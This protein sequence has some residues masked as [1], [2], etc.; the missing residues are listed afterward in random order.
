MNI[1]VIPARGGSKR[2][3]RKN[4]RDFCGKPMIAWSIEAAKASGLF[5]SIVV[6]TD[7]DQI[8]EIGK[9]FGAEV[10]FRRPA[11]LADDH[12][13]VRPVVIHAI[14][15]AERRF[16]RPKYI[17]CVMPTAPFI[18]VDDLKNGL[19]KLVSTGSDFAFTVTSFPYPIQRALKLLGTGGVAMFQNEYLKTRS[20][21]LEPAYHDAGQYYWGRTEAFLSGKQTF[22]KYSTPIVLPRYRAHDIDT[23]EDWECAELMFRCLINNQDS[24]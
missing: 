24:K 20:Q 10:P 21:D 17:C 19:R 8:A 23:P 15:E 4:I 5:E 1:C 12:A 16:G 9:L 2:I 3:P 7:D 22:D 6:S 18:Q 11:E 14:R 13:T